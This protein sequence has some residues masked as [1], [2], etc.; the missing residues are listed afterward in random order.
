MKPALVPVPPASAFDEQ[1]QYQRALDSRLNCQ[2]LP[3]PKKYAGLLPCIIPH[4]LSVTLGIDND[5]GKGI[6]HSIE[7]ITPASEFETSFAAL[8]GKVCIIYV[9]SVRPLET[10]MLMESQSQEPA[11]QSRSTTLDLNENQHWKD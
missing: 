1:G 6:S 11:H 3:P 10:E 8:H 5:D 7:L 2:V 9:L 4:R